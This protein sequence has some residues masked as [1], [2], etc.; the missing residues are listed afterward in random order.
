M[1]D[2][3]GQSEED[4]EE[5]GDEDED[6]EG[7]VRIDSGAVFEDLV[8]QGSE[9]IIGEQGWGVEE[10][11]LR[12]T[13]ARHGG[14]AG[15]RS[16]GRRRRCVTRCRARARARRWICSAPASRASGRRK[17]R[18]SRDVSSWRAPLV[19]RRRLHVSVAVQVREAVDI[20]GFGDG[21]TRGGV[22]LEALLD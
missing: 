3:C 10:G 13:G 6:G 18:R 8:C 14:R 1:L 21:E 9:G 2:V 20:A 22:E 5:D 11:A 16:S 15:W 17:G 19:G 4:E 7:E 12:R